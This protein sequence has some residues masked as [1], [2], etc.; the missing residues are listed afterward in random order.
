MQQYQIGDKVRYIKYKNKIAEIV[1]YIDA[2]KYTEE[3]Y[4]IQ[5][6]SGSIMVNDNVKPDQLMKFDISKGQINIFDNLLKI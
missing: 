2:T 5:Y 4:V 1:F 3:S 6:V